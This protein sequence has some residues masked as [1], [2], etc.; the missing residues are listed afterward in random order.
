MAMLL[1]VNI[2]IWDRRYIGQVGAHHKQ[3]YVCTPQGGTYL[4]NV[5]HTMEFIKQSEFESIHVLYDAIAKHYEYFANNA[6]GEDIEDGPGPEVQTAETGTCKEVREGEN[7][8]AVT[9][10]IPRNMTVGEEETLKGSRTG[11]TNIR[12]RRELQRS[13]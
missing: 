5:A 13:E 11:K 10:E 3:L 12:E 2:V 7:A 4:R 9:T 1:K 8:G 6:A